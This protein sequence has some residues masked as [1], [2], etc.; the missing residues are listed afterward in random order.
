VVDY[1]MSSL[2]MMRVTC[3]STAVSVI[4]NDSAMPRL[5]LPLPGVR[6]IELLGVGPT[7]ESAVV[8]VR[9]WSP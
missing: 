2:L 5:D 7:L 6:L 8:P 3:F 9:T 4:T 1:P